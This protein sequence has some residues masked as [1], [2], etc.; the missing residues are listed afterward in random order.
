ML[1]EGGGQDELAGGDGGQQVGAA[2]A[3]QREGAGHQGG[4]GGDGDGAAADLGEQDGD[5]EQAEAVGAGTVWA[6]TVWAE[7]QQAGPGELLPEAGAG[8]GLGAQGSTVRDRAGQDLGGQGGYGLL[9][10]RE[11]EVHQ[12][13]GPRGMAA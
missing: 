4:Q 2:P 12:R 8:R 9:A 10:V 7:G 6:G 3:E 5:V 1:A 13:D 11:G